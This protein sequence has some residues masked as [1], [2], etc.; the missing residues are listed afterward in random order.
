MSQSE[1]EPLLNQIDD[2]KR[3]RDRYQSD[4]EDAELAMAEVLT[5]LRNGQVDE[6]QRFLEMFV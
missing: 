1:V 3:E 6:A 5:K 4:A 2:L